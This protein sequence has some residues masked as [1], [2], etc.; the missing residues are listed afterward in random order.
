M[1]LI[2]LKILLSSTILIVWLLRQNVGSTFRAGGVANLKEEFAFYGLS[3]ELFY[4][5]GTLKITLALE[6]TQNALDNTNNGASP[7]KVI[8]V[9]LKQRAKAIC[10]M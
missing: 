3:N 6:D 8:L 1:L 10:P 2:L 7:S 9:R 4:L 5:A